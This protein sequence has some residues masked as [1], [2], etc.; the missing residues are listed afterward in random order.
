MQRFKHYGNQ[1]PDNLRKD[2]RTVEHIKEYIQHFS[3]SAICHSRIH[4]GRLQGLAQDQGTLVSNQKIFLRALY[5][6]LGSNFSLMNQQLSETAAAHTSLVR[7]AGAVE[8]GIASMVPEHVLRTL[9][10][11]GIDS[12]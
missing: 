3:H 12:N 8:Q 4:M 7:W 10:H 1:N 5:S 9:N 6:E 11:Q 2:L